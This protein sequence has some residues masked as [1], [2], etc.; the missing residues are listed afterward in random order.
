MSQYRN[1]LPQMGNKPFLTDSGLETTL[2][3]HEEMDLP[4][5][6]AFD[7]M[8]HEAG[9][10]TLRSY[11][12]RHL[13]IAREKGLGFILESPTWRANPDWAQQLGYDSRSLADANRQAIKLMLE[14]RA[15][16][17]SVATPVVVSGNLGPR[18][19]GYRVAAAMSSEQA[20]T[21]HA[22][23][24]AVFKEAAVD[25]VA[26]FTI[27][28]VEEAIGI[29]MAAR[30]AE[31]PVVISFT[32]ETDGRLPTGDSLAQAINRTDDST[33]GYVAYYMINCA[34]PEHFDGVLGDLGEWKERIRGVRANASRRSHAEL[35][36][37]TDLDAGDPQEL[38]YQYRA[39]KS[40][41]PGL[42]VLGGC[43]GTDHRHIEAMGSVCCQS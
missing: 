35:D 6:A 20:R 39:L 21:Y 27:N 31:I 25:M 38:A 42:T 41:L 5:F 17:D 3:F 12:E 10:T 19:D 14:L 9:R 11:F 15:E 23:Q 37:S 33:G 36:E 2:I 22:D 29:A 28:Y 7:L 34:H 16:Y 8:R 43:C 40:L 4:C 24:I 32:L 1:D 18:G 13:K 30:D 26:A